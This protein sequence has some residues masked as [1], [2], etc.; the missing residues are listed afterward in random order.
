[1]GVAPANAVMAACG[2]PDAWAHAQAWSV[3]DTAFGEGQHLLAIWNAWQR[4]PQ[5]PHQLHYV[6][7]APRAPTA[8]PVTT[9]RHDCGLEGLAQILHS[10]CRELEGGFHRILLDAGRVSLTLCLGDVPAVL[11]ELNFRTDTVIGDAPADKWAVQRLA[12]RCRRGT[13]YWLRLQ[14]G[15]GSAM[16]ALPALLHAAGFRPDA[17]SVTLD[18]LSG[19]FDPRWNIATSRNPSDL[20]T[21]SLG[22]CA[23]IGAGITGATV[24]HALAQRG[25]QVQVFDRERNPAAG[26]S[27]L[28]AGLAVPHVSS[29]DSPRSRLSRSGTR[30]MLQLA[31][32]LIVR[33]RDWDPSGVLERKTDALP[34]WHPQAGWIKP[35]ALVHALLANTAITFT[36]L[37]EIAS[38]RRVGKLWQ[39]VTTQGNPLGEFDLLVVANALG[40]APLLQR[41]QVSTPLDPALQT[42]LAALQAVHGTVSYGTYGEVLENL[43][44]TPVN[45]NGCFIPHIPTSTVE[46]WLVGASFETDPRRAADLWGQHALNMQRLQTLFPEGGSDLVDALERAK[47]S[48]WSST[49]CVTHDR[50]PLVGPVDVQ[51]CPGFWLCIGMG[52]RGLS[53]SALCA[54]L[55]V[56]RIGAEPWP[57]EASLARSLDAHRRHR[58]RPAATAPKPGAG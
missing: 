40:S 13:R 1:M 9:D 21:V 42:K 26:A 22:R 54:E 37:T 43:P 8:T 16:T 55:L 53:F 18:S 19:S 4:D 57:V 15:A 49:R 39:P 32:R 41:L 56:A 38:L 35:V 45:G 27:G 46:Q 12:R 31:E 44:A 23:V 51:T 47:V 48:H 11:D 25:W 52:S 3:L 36:G 30:L 2:L 24:A 7:I 6:G 20:A 10:H 33:S 14:Q 29:D 58:I 28:P 17:I 5:R 50:L 34:R